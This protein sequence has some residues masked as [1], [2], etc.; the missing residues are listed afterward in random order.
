MY[1]VYGV[2]KLS[3]LSIILIKDIVITLNADI[4]VFTQGIQNSW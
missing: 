2:S 3:N 4:I 1:T